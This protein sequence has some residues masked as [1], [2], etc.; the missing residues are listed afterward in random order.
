MANA[1]AAAGSSR[2]STRSERPSAAP[3]SIHTACSIGS[4]ACA[5]PRTA[6]PRTALNNELRGACSGTG[7]ASQLDQAIGLC[8]LE[9]PADIAQRIDHGVHLSGLKT[10]RCRHS[11]DLG[12]R[13]LPL[14]LRGVDGVLHGA[15]VDPGQDRILQAPND[16]L[17]SALRCARP[18]SATEVDG[19]RQN[20]T[21]RSVGGFVRKSLHRLEPPRAPAHRRWGRGTISAVRT[22]SDPYG[23]PPGAPRSRVPPGRRRYIVA[24]DVNEAAATGYCSADAADRQRDVLGAQLARTAVDARTDAGHGHDDNNGDDP[25]RRREASW[26]ERRQGASNCAERA[27]K[28]GA[29]VDNISARRTPCSRFAPVRQPKLTLDDP[30]KID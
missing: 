2:T 21:A 12:V 4:R 17:G 15:R 26:H 24:R 1:F 28:S 14:G 18:S 8:A 23:A 3:R 19:L 11:L 13:R 5:R 10:R 29:A 7:R 20:A 6:G 9:R 22:R 16:S 25:A 27:R 30:L